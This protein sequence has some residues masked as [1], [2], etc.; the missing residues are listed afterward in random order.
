[1]LVEAIETASP[2]VRLTM[3]YDRLELDLRRADDGFEA[4]DLKAINDSLVHGQEILTTLRTTLRADVWEGA[5][6]L[7][8]LYD[9]LHGELLGANLAKDRA[10]MQ[11][12]AA[13]I[14]Q[15]ATAWRQ[16]ASTGAD[17]REQE[18]VGGPV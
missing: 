7:G 8:T 11:A 2:A 14:A 5:A 17:A 18:P 6:R 12:A 4:G 9:F 10:R 3:L 16:A 15:L 1:Y 13:L